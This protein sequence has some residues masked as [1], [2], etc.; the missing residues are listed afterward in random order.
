M[1][2]LARITLQSVQILFFVG[3]WL[4][5][6]RL[7][8]FE[9]WPMPAGVIGLVV[10]TALL[11]TGLMAH[12]HIESGARRLLAEMPLFFIPP[13]LSVMDFGQV[14]ARYGFALLAAVLLGSLVVMSCTGLIVD[15]VFHLESRR[16]GPAKSL[17]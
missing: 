3:L 5:G 17:C 9:H 12:R 4:I 1:K 10:V 8:D 7:A 14:F 11:M 2:L 6:D 16:Q 13:L 15:W